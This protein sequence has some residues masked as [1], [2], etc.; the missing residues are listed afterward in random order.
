[1]IGDGASEVHGGW[2][3]VT[4]RHGNGSVLLEH[5][6]RFAGAKHPTGSWVL[7]FGMTASQGSRS[8][9]LSVPTSS[10]Q[11]YPAQLKL[12]F[13]PHITTR[14]ARSADVACDAD[15][16]DVADADGAMP[17]EGLDVPGLPLL[18]LLARQPRC[19]DR[20]DPPFSACLIAGP[21]AG[22]F[23]GRKRGTE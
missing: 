17:D 3:A 8:S 13:N 5:G 9:D 7:R 6:G 16:E 14:S 15:D 21:T 2:V 12:R 1:M 19:C 11:I 22:C 18:L 20:P 4:A 23:E 10:D